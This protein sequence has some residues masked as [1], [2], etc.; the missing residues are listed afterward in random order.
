VG[1]E[2]VWEL[3][4]SGTRLSFVPREVIVNRTFEAADTAL[5]AEQPGQISKT[6]FIGC[7]FR[8]GRYAVWMN[9]QEDVAFVN[10]TFDNTGAAPAG[11]NEEAAIRVQDCQRVL[12]SHATIRNGAPKHAFRVHK[13]SA[14]I[15]LEH[16]TIDSDGNGFLL[17][18]YSG[19]SEPSL[20]QD[21]ELA[22][23][24]ATV[25]GPDYFNPG[26][27]GSVVRLR[28]R[29]MSLA[30]RGS[31]SWAPPTSASGSDY[32]WDIAGFTRD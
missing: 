13:Q 16:A 21:L 25:A 12:F 4:V 8:G 3:P 5:L 17:G 20:V 23:V 22:N 7:T 32:G 2:F 19:A 9:D 24:T 1:R 31:T 15:A 30:P 28:I 14:Q 18:T 26:A 27:P 29:A 6:V 10:C 11:M